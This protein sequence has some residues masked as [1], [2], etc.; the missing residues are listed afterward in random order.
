MIRKFHGKIFSK[1]KLY[2]QPTDVVC[3]E[4]MF[5]VVSIWQSVHGG[6]GPM[7]PLRIQPH[8]YSHGDPTQIPIQCML[9]YTSGQ[10]PR[11]VDT[12]HPSRTPWANTPPWAY[13]PRADTSRQTTLLSHR[14]DTPPLP[15]TTATAAE[16]THPTG[17]LSC[18]VLLSAAQ[19]IPLQINKGYQVN[20]SQNSELMVEIS[21][22]HIFH[23][24]GMLALL[25][26]NFFK[27]QALMYCRTFSFSD[28]VTIFCV[29]S[30]CW[31][32]WTDKLKGRHNIIS[33]QT[34]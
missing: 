2:L 7:W 30:S 13:T 32:L 28:F 29:T 11:W 16:G 18:F 21:K 20:A 10:T 19:G 33:S 8:P 3:G 24:D 14:A 6:G 4:A 22:Q 9:G 1:V 34:S 5:S 23:L 12:P 27:W 31:N 25:L 26:N 17:M 15:P